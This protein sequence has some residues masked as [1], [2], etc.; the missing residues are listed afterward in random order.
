MYCQSCGEEIEA[1][2]K[3]CEHC[4][5]SVGGVE[6]NEPATADE[7]E[8][9]ASTEPAQSTE[10]AAA[11]GRGGSGENEVAGGLE[12]NVAGALSYLLGFITGLVFFLIEEE[13][14]FVR[15]HAAQ[16]I[17]VFGGL[18]VLGVVL[19]VVTGFLGATGGL[20]IGLFLLVFTL[21]SFA[22]WLA[23]V[24]L[25]IFLMVKAYQGETPRIPIAAGIADDLV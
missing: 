5:A 15:F 12:P 21:V 24:V 8:A 7:S 6:G 3:F 13:D 11:G 1:G 22:I 25:W 4:G 10:T 9:P 18:F 23:V 19:N 17:V 14:E 16:S 2:A 20:F